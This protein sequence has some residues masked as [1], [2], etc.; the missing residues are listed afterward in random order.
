MTP[1]IEWMGSLRLELLGLLVL[2]WII[3]YFCIWKSIKATG[4]V[5]YFTAT[6]PYLLLFV[7]MARG[8]TL[9]GAMEGLKFLFYPKWEMM[10]DAK[11]WV[12]AA[13]QVLFLLVR[14]H[15]FFV[16]HYGAV[17]VVLC[18]HYIALHPA[19]GAIETQAHVVPQVR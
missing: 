8:C 12:Y 11:V 6:V 5:V 13:A 16:G 3:V 2:A 15:L 10:L 14:V 4:K 19:Q 18:L 9:P 1:G 17:S 7:F